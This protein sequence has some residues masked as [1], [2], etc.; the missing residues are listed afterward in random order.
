LI[1]V[2]QD[3][4]EGGVVM[5]K[6]V[7]ILMAVLMLFS[8]FQGALRVNV[9]KAKSTQESLATDPNI[10]AAI[11]EELLNLLDKLIPDNASSP[12]YDDQNWDIS[13][14][15]F[16]AWIV[17][18]AWSEG[19]LGG[20]VAHSQGNQVHTKLTIDGKKIPVGDKLIHRG[21]GAFFTFST[22]IGPFQIDNDQQGVTGDNWSEWP[23]IDKLDYKKALE[24][25][26]LWHKNKF[27]GERL[28]LGDF[29][30]SAK[31]VWYGVNPGDV[32]ARWKQ[33]T[34][35]EW[36]YYS[37]NGPKDAGFTDLSWDAIKNSLISNAKKL[38]FNTSYENNVQDCGEDKV[39]WHINV[40]TVSVSTGSEKNVIFE[41]KR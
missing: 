41:G 32:S 24:S 12:Y 37:K 36:D 6:T 16:K 33:V 26:L 25:V 1:E 23:T 2:K 13:K 38:T 35:T 21:A 19:N 22:G 20:Y 7:A 8:L 11:D 3:F 29:Q 10:T 9:I 14:S 27:G 4:K 34:G 15:Q 18:I 28:T 31:L 17:T 30:S 39:E 5:K 40:K